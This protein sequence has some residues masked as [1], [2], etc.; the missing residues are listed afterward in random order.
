MAAHTRGKAC[1]AALLALVL[2]GATGERADAAANLTITGTATGTIDGS[3]FSDA[4]I[5][6]VG[7]FDWSTDKDGSGSPIAAYPLISLSFDI[8]TE[9]T[10]TSAPGASLFGVV[11]A[12]T[13]HGISFQD[14]SGDVMGE[15]FDASTWDAAAQSVLLSDPTEALGTSSFVLP[16]PGGGS[17]MISNFSGLDA[18]ASIL[19]PEPASLSL[20]GLGLAATGLLRRRR[21]TD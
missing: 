17:V 8:A 19:A 18:T 2:A 13:G 9:G 10:Y 20:L 11:E 5:T 16:L 1:A 7:T 21:S 15:V 14:A 4:A 3:P 6:A 12:F